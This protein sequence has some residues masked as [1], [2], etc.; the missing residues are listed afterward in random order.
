MRPSHR[1]RS[2]SASCHELVS[3]KRTS[4]SAASPSSSPEEEE[5]DFLARWRSSSSSMVSGLS[6]MDQTGSRRLN[7]ARPR[8]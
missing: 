4:A 7:T 2:P 8:R 3:W 1:L 6:R 5:W